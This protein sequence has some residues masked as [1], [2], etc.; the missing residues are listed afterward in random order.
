MKWLQHRLADRFAVGKLSSSV[1][2]AI[3]IL[4]HNLK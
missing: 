1:A 4:Q 2:K 3:N